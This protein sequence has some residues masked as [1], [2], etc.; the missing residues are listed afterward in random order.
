MRIEIHYLPCLQ[1]FHCL[2]N[3]EQ[4]RFEVQ[5]HF[6]KQTY[7]NRCRILGAQGTLELIV[8][9]LHAGAKQKT[10]DVQ[11]DNQQAWARTQQRSIQACYGKS[12][13]YEHFAPLFFEVYQKKHKFLVD[14][15]LNF[16]ELIFQIFGKKLDYELTTEFEEPSVDEV[17]QQLRAKG[18]ANPSYVWSSPAYQQCFGSSFVPN[19]SVLDLLMNQGPHGLAFARPC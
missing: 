14:L 18:P 10:L 1:A 8:P 9:I 13:Y 17:Y 2:W 11:L 5:E 19:L 4:L 12:A 15:N 16:L 7:R 6:P 3:A